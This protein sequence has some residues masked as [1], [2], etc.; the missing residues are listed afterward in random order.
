MEM[1]CKVSSAILI[2]KAT[3]TYVMYDQIKLAVGISGWFWWGDILCDFLF[4]LGFVMFCFLSCSYGLQ[5]GST[6][7]FQVLMMCC[8]WRLET[9]RTQVVCSKE[10][11]K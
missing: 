7:V 3:E 8:D 6:V 10:S 9:L 11:S 5:M 1:D 2:Y 4:C